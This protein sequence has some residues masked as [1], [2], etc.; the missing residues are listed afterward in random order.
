[1][2]VDKSQFSEVIFF[3]RNRTDWPHYCWKA[4]KGDPAL[5]KLEA[6]ALVNRLLTEQADFNAEEQQW[7]AKILN[8][9]AR[10]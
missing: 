5:Q 4:V 1:V 2:I 8:F 6:I 7:K 9:L 3:F 10:P